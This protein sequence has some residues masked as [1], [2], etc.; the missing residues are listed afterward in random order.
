MASTINS[1]STVLI[2]TTTNIY[3]I[4]VDEVQVIE[5]GP[6]GP[7]GIQGAQGAT[8]ATGSSITGSTGNTG[9]QGQTGFT[10]STGPTGS[11]GNVGNTGSTGSTGPTGSTGI[12]GPTGSTGSTGVT[13]AQGNTGGTGGT[14]AMGNTGPTGATGSTGAT[15]PIGPTGSTGA[16]G[17]TGSTGPTGST[18]STGSTGLTGPT[19]PTGSTGATGANS[20]VAGPTGPTG[21]TGATGANSTVAGPTGPTGSTGAAGVIA[22]T[23]PITYSSGTQTVALNIGSSLTTSASN[24]IVD[25]TV[26][27]YLANANTFTASPQQITVN[28]AGNKGLII[29]GAASQTADLQEWQN[30]AGTVLGGANALAQIYTGSIAP[31][32]VA[33]G[34]A[35]TAATGD[36]TT[37]TIT[38]TSAHGLAVGDLV[39][40]AGVTPT[41]YNGTFLV[42]AVAST[43][44]S[45]ANATTGAQTVAGTVS[46]PAQASVT[47]RSAGSV[48]LIVK[49]AASQTADLQEWQN[50]SGT[51]IS[52]VNSTGGISLPRTALIRFNGGVGTDRAY[53]TSNTNNDLIFAT[54]SGVEGFRLY[55]GSIPSGAL[56]T[57]SNA[58]AQGLI[59]KAAASQTADLQQWQ[60][61]AGTVL[62]KVDANGNITA[63]NYTI[64]PITAVLLFGGM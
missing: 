61:S 46:A 41:G 47:A 7:Q 48:G 58:G 37:A 28:A 42:T 23:A 15:G 38:T 39:T 62:A 22:A 54:A 36:G 1:I 3:N 30:S 26:V 2:P 60:N 4:A 17:S 49:G 9:S 53:I 14:G 56:I 31:A 12:T 24:L 13:G 43:T 51:T 32:L 40:V 64:D 27:P 5:L 19:G 8:G 11:T 59:I 57:N 52:W 55:G 34:G 16:T 21:S 45:Y 29:K 10:G 50:S 20:T 35:T 63:A 44:I 6:V 25:S 18:G 33:T